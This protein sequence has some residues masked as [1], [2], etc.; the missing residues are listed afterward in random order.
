VT[1]VDELVGAQGGLEEGCNMLEQDIGL[2][3]LVVVQDVTHSRN[4][5]EV[6]N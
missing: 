6:S 2:A 1:I 3:D 4:S 5:T